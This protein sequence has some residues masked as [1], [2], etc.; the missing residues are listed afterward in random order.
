MKRKNI[1]LTSLIAALM[2]TLC[3][4]GALK[5][6]A[7]L[8][9]YDFDADKVPSVNAIIGAERQVTGVLTGVST[10]GMH[11]KEYTYKSDTVKEDLTTYLYFLMDEGWIPIV[12]FDLNEG[13]T[14]EAQLAIESAD[15]G[16]ILIV[17]ATFEPN[18]YTIK[19]EKGE[20]TL[21]L[22]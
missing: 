5:D 11:Y 1:L 16:Q 19:V 10:N 18:E 20:G 3:A 21:T 17:T 22:K 8:T 13:D 12:D 9:E 15:T 6:A 4:C 14:G 2:L 7:K